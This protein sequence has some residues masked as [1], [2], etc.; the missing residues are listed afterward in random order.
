LESRKTVH[1]DALA[2]VESVLF[3]KVLVVL[4]IRDAYFALAPMRTILPH[5][6]LLVMRYLL[7]VAAI[8]FALQTSLRLPLRSLLLPALRS[9]IV[10]LLL[11]LL[12]PLRPLLF[13]LLLLLLLNTLLLLL[14]LFRLLLFHLPLLLLLLLLLFLRLFLLP[15][16]ISLLC[17]LLLARRLL[18]RLLLAFSRWMFFVLL[19]LLLLIALRVR[20]HRSRC[21]QHQQRPSQNYHT[22]LYRRHLRLHFSLFAAAFITQSVSL[23]IRGLRPETA[24]DLALPWFGGVSAP[25]FSES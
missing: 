14:L 18:L 1:D 21:A 15:L 12:T 10:S 24:P 4:R 8:P 2:D 25:T 19:L 5:M 13:L 16:L 17:W 20:A 6:R 23:E 3:S 9:L 22:L 7:R 11:L